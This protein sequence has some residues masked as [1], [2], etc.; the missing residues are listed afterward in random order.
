[1]AILKD[2]NEETAYPPLAKYYFL[3]GKTLR[4]PAI[5]WHGAHP[6]IRHEAHVI[7]LHPACVHALAARLL[8]DSLE[9]RNNRAVAN[10]F[11]SR[12]SMNT[13]GRIK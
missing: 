11:Y 5:F 10:E 13:D 6:S 8:R 7:W 3:C 9:V 12:Y 2:I 1:M 4:P